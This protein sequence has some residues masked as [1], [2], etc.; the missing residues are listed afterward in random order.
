MFFIVPLQGDIIGIRVPF[1]SLLAY[2][3]RKREYCFFCTSRHVDLYV[4][5]KDGDLS[6]N[7]LLIL[8]IGLLRKD[9]RKSLS[10]TGNNERRWAA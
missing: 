8:N 7:H 2:F 1:V 3:H 10:S 9:R 6:V 5:E 4:G